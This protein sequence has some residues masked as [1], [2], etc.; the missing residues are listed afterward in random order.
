MFY[1][2]VYDKIVIDVIENPVF[3]RWIKTS[4][5]FRETDETSAAAIF[6]SDFSTKYHLSG[7]D[8][9]ENGGVYKDVILI[10]IQE[11]EYNNIKSTLANKIIQDDGSEIEISELRTRKISEMSEACNAAITSGFDIILSD[12]ITYHFSLEITDQM[13]ISKLA[14]RATNGV[15]PLPWHADGGLCKFYSSEDILAINSQMEFL[16]EYH[17]TYF[18]SL[19]NY[20]LN[21]DDRD[22]ILN[23]QYGAVIPAAYQSEVLKALV[24]Q[25]GGK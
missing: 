8:L 16:V 21:M 3:L 7:K 9:I 24:S 4:K 11:A 25:N 1:K 13:K 12:G 6:S 2:V 5:R 10:E 19:K 18:N 17:T 23:I 20:I 22:T 14:D 15:S